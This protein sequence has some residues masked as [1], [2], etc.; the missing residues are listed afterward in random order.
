MI[1][2][3]SMT[4]LSVDA[5]FME[6]LFKKPVQKRESGKCHLDNTL[7]QYNTK[8]VPEHCTTILKAVLQ[9]I[10]VWPWNSKC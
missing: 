2:L 4:L 9:K 1:L 10:C 3:I 8:I 7:I 5:S 6:R